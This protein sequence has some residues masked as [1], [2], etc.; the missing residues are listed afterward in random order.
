MNTVLGCIGIVSSIGISVFGSVAVF[1]NPALQ[2]PK[3]KERIPT[4]SR[5]AP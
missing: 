5:V 2:D 1:S 3:R 4:K